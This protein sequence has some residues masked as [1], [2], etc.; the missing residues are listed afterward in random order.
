MVTIRPIE[1]TNQENFI[2]NLLLRN[3]HDLTTLNK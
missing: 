1:G 2:F 3:N